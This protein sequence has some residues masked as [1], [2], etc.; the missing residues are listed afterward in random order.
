MVEYMG[1]SF[2]IL[3]AARAQGLVAEGYDREKSPDGVGIQSDILTDEG[4]KEQL[5]AALT[6]KEDGAAVMAP[7][8]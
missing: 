2:G 7:C 8:F 5:H 1:G 6:I 3:M 4:F